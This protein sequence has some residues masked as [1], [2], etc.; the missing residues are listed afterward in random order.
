MPIIR[1]FVEGKLEIEVLRPIFQGSPIPQQGGSK[2]SL[3]PRALTERRENKVV[4]GFLRDR[5]FDFD[6]PADHS[7]PAVDSVDGGVPFGWRWCR[8][9]LENYLIDPALV[10]ES[11]A[12]SLPDVEEALR[13]SA[14]KI[15]GYEASRWT[16]GALR[17]VMPPHYEL[18]TRPDGLHDIDL[19]TA[20]IP[21]RSTHG[22]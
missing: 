12:W 22:R 18:R 11:M 2:Y 13:K 10:S 5:D 16:I 1:L 9:E 20:P 3:K 14:A 6:P 8:H 19:P 4:A 7:R 17:R 21:R 15:R